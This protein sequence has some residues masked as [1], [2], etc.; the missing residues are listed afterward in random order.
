MD[1]SHWVQPKSY[2]KLFECMIVCIESRSVRLENNNE[3]SAHCSLYLLG[4]SSPPISASQ[5]AGTIGVHHHA[6]LIFVVFV[7]KGFTMLPGAGLD[8][9]G[10]NWT[11][12]AQ[13]R[14]IAIST[15]QSAHCN[16]CLPGS[17]NSLPQLPEWLRLQMECHCRPGWSAVVQS[18][19]TATPAS[20]VQTVLL[21]QPSDFLRQGLTPSPRLECSVVNT[22]HCKQGFM[23]RRLV[24]NSWPKGLT[25]LSRL[26]CSGVIMAH[27]TLDLLD[28]SDSPTSYSG[29]EAN[30]TLHISFSMDSFC[31][32]VFCD[33]V[34]LCHQ[35]GVQCSNLHSAAGTTGV[36]HH[37]QLIFVFLVETEFH[38]VRPPGLARMVSSSSPCDLPTSA[39]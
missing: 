9:L 39:S 31:L 11:A 33:G 24:S 14:L 35:A 36:H 34:S 2:L 22:A 28:S 3:I 30:R 10:S 38:H 1:V 12:V 16:L 32:F 26:E 25:L 20:Q 37:D 29:Y 17:S 4:S 27:C 7:E 13:S 6:W 8:L 5:I 15:S 23:F 19:L 18:R 21:P